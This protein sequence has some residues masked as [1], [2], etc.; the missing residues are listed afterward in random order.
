MKHSLLILL[1]F[2]ALQGFAQSPP[3]S[4]AVNSM[5]DEQ[6]AIIAPGGE[7]MYF[8]RQYHPEN[9]GGSRDPG[10]IWYAEKQ[11][12][13]NWGQPRNLGALN[14]SYYNGII[15]FAEGGRKVYLH[16]HYLEDNRKPTTDGI[17]FAEKTLNG[18]SR[19]K[20]VQVPY[21]YN[22][23]DHQSG[24]LHAGGNIMIMSLQSFDTRGAEDLYVLFRRSDGSWTEPSNLGRDINSA[25][26][27]MTPY[28]APD[29][30]TLY[31][32]SNGYEGFGS[33][34]IFMSV[35]L[36]ESWQSWSNPKNLGAGV[37]S[38]GTELYYRVNR[39]E[40][41]F[42]YFTTT[43][44]SDGLGDIKRISI[45]PEEEDI[46]EEPVVEVVPEEEPDIKHTPPAPQPTEAAEVR[47]EEAE[48]EPVL[49]KGIIQH[50]NTAQ[51]VAALL[52]VKLL[53][54]D[55]LLISADTLVS[56]QG[57]YAFNLPAGQDYELMVAAEGFISQRNRVL[58]SESSQLDDTDVIV[59][60]FELTPIEVGSTVNL[61]NV[62]F[63]RGTA[64]MLPG[65]AENLDAVVEF[66][67]ENAKVEIEV[68]GH[69]DNRGRADLNK[70]LSLERAEAVKRYM[71]RQGID[72]SRISVAGY[73]GSRPIASNAIEEERMKNRRV[74]FTILKK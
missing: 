15:G 26:Q 52:E 37:N 53:R 14:N 8:T 55:S 63:D 67:N 33:R 39:N 21:F 54:N 42:A 25:Y 4:I 56:E 57:V 1:L 11:E 24:S 27:E 73:G 62:L 31:F 35:R 48:E 43:Q 12:D 46:L 70:I 20:S 10:D 17:S 19:P 6:N 9:I 45:E 60:N 50:K 74:E 44:N 3:E 18:W 72:G 22:K 34:D 38:E 7:R 64:S 58:L 40:P 51:P 32:A 2:S 68:A 59:R 30:K 69:T 5:A 61:E 13:G 47:E 36:D 23:S 65:S 66:L 71:V 29:G 49:F 41:D 28:L 16:H